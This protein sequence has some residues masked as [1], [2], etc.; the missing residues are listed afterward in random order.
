MPIGL[1]MMLF[2]GG[3]GSA[4]LA[5][6]IAMRLEREPLRLRA[7][8]ASVAPPKQQPWDVGELLRDD[9]LRSPPGPTSPGGHLAGPAGPLAPP[10]LFDAA[11]QL[12]PLYDVHNAGIVPAP[13]PPPLPEH[14]PPP[15]SREALSAMAGVPTALSSSNT[16]DS[17]A[18]DGSRGTS[19]GRELAA[20]ARATDA[21]RRG[22]RTRDRR[23]AVETSDARA[24]DST[25][26]DARQP[27]AAERVAGA[28]RC[29]KHPD[30]WHRARHRGPRRRRAG[31]RG[32]DR[33]RGQGRRGRKAA[34]AV[35]DRS[36]RSATPSSAPK[37]ALRSCR[38][39]RVT[40]WISTRRSNDRVRR[41][42]RSLTS[43]E[44]QPRRSRARASPHPRSSHPHTGLPHRGLP[45]SRATLPRRSRARASPHLRSDRSRTDLPHPRSSRATLPRPSRVR[46]SLHLRSIRR[47][48]RTPPRRRPACR[49]SRSRRRPRRCRPLGRPRRAPARRPHARS[50]RRRCRGS[51]STCGSTAR[52][53][54]CTS[55]RGVRSARWRRCC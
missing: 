20:A 10:P 26:A 17:A 23:A 44:N 51:K 9:Q 41:R 38:R 1:G 19:E 36:H 13:P 12:R 18:A 30:R 4:S 6:V 50:A 24:R 5:G 25:A 3:I 48:R 31:H 15:V 14:P 40:R 27:H 43:R 22:N 28:R 21:A 37:R 8:A 35:G 52:S 29:G 45:T 55:E 54:A 49:M 46:G 34:L 33:C 47:L 7:S 42:R 11:P 32:R 39:H 2:W 16:D 53:A